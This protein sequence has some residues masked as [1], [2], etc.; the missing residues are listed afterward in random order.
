MPS[1]SVHAPALS[2]S[3]HSAVMTGSA[4]VG[5]VTAFAAAG[6]VGDRSKTLL[7]E[8]CVTNA[9]MRTKLTATKPSCFQGT[10]PLSRMGLLSDKQHGE[11]TTWHNEGD[12]S[13]VDEHS[14][15]GCATVGGSTCQRARAAFALR[16]GVHG[17]GFRWPVA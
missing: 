4:V 1:G 16:L 2:C 10:R 11:V 6:L 9:D 5:A 12:G 3:A 14:L 8:D 13:T 15:S 7:Y 17:D